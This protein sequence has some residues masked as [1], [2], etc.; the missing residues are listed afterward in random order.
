MARL[1]THSTFWRSTLIVGGALIS[2]EIADE[3]DR[4]GGDEAA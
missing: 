2:A 4:G 3:V 1:R